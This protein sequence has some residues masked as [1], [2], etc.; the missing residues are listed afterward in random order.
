MWWFLTDAARKNLVD[1]SNGKVVE[2]GLRVADGI[3]AS[4][5]G[6]WYLGEESRRG[7]LL[8][9][10]VCAYIHL[11]AGLDMAKFIGYNMEGCM[12]E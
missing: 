11:G 2:Q 8:N 5:V 7:S 9:V 4:L 6:S 1:F 3:I 12:N 10:H